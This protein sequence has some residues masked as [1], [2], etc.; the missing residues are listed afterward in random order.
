MIV[1][2]DNYDSFT[3]NLVQYLGTLGAELEVYRNDAITVD[4]LA[5]RPLDGLVISPG[6]GEPRAAGIS[7]A[8]IQALAGR[9]PILGVCLGHQALAEVYGGK[10][11]RAQRLMHGKTSPILHKGRGLFAGLD[12][13]FEATRYHSLIV[14]RETLPSALELIAWTPEGE[15]MGLKHQDHETWGVQFH[16]ESI[17]T[18]PGLKLIEN[19]LVL[20]RQRP[21]G[22]R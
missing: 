10:V 7:E 2:L 19:F 17:L 6:P 11:V 8:A 1:V 3:Y 16:P 13:P 18:K 9:V 21:V 12:N 14:E 15:I 22:A 4:D 5:A 20:C